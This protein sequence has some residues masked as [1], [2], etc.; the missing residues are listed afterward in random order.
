VAQGLAWCVF[1]MLW[2]L[3]LIGEAMQ[4][5]PIKPTL[6]APGIQLLKLEYEELL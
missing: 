3:P 5:A 4:V 6:T 1:E 2:V